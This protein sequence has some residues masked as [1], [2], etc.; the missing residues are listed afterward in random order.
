[1]N[2][3]STMIE[4]Q[5]WE[6]WTR[7]YHM[8]VFCFQGRLLQCTIFEAKRDKLYAHNATANMVLELKWSQFYL[9]FCHRPWW[10]AARGR[11]A[12]W[13]E[14]TTE[15]G[16]KFRVPVL[17]RLALIL[18]GYTWASEDL[19]IFTLMW[20]T[21]P[22]S[23]LDKTLWIFKPFTQSST[24]TGISQPELTHCS[25][26]AFLFQFFWPQ[27]SPTTGETRTGMTTKFRML[28]QTTVCLFGDLRMNQGLQRV[29][30]D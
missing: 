29:K 1:M 18:P 16:Y 21:K 12:R 3:K 8:W 7:W 9:G 4:A 10:T 19:H 20:R 13:H 30:P 27:S 23:G 11:K 26:G 2:I 25:I 24:R 22:V 15:S 28:T 6:K 14:W 5:T 17:E